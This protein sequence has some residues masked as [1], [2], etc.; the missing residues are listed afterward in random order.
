MT[1][2]PCSVLLMALGAVG[3][4][5][6]VVIATGNQKGTSGPAGYV[7]LAFMLL[8]GVVGVFLFL[9]NWANRRARILVD[10][11]GLWVENGNQRN[12]IPWQG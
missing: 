9:A 6:G 12:V 7:G 11:T 4:I 10:A 3:V 1:G 2:L 5:G 8:L